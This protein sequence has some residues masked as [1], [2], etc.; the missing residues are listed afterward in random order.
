MAWFSLVQKKTWRSNS[1]PAL[2]QK[3][4]SGADGEGDKQEVIEVGFFRGVLGKLARVQ[5][6]SGLFQVLSLRLFYDPSQEFFSISGFCPP[7]HSSDGCCSYRECN[8]PRSWLGLFPVSKRGHISSSG[9]GRKFMLF[10]PFQQNT[11]C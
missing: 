7:H 5:R 4:K 9:N 10:W 1:P 3:D 8:Q 6:D 11:F 2:V